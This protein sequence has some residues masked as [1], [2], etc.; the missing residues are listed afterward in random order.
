MR[1]SDDESPVLFS[2]SLDLL[3]KNF[4]RLV[5]VVHMFTCGYSLLSSEDYK[6]R[7]E[8]K[9]L[10]FGQ[11]EAAQMSEQTD[12]SLI[13]EMQPAHEASPDVWDSLRETS[14]SS[15]VNVFSSNPAEE[16]YRQMIRRHKAWLDSITHE[17]PNP[18]RHYRIGVY[19]RYFN[20]TKYDNY[21]EYHKKQFLDT[22]ALCP[23]WL[24]VDFY[25]DEGQN[26]PYM[27]NAPD[28][29][30][31]LDDCFSGK[32]DLIVTQKVSNVSRKPQEI[33]FC[34]RILASLKKPVGIYFISEN[35]FTLASYYQDDLHD[36]SFLPGPEWKLLPDEIIDET[37]GH[38]DETA[39]DA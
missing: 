1:A 36:T 13:P 33:A 38:I 6:L 30:R 31:L 12:L 10:P 27:E 7:L 3:E 29:C 8:R 4:V 26:A 25:V 16:H 9:A 14:V 20:Q 19:I 21:L 5:P 2:L 15:A 22:I 37:W 34:A 35:L 23:N 17:C 39:D 11:K 28:W 18:Y 32:V 24:L